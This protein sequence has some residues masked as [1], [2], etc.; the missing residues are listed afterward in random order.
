MPAQ[1]RDLIKGKRFLLLQEMA[2]D[3]GYDDPGLAGLGVGGT[4]LTGTGDDVPAQPAQ[5]S[6]P[7]VDARFVMQASRFTRPM[8]SAYRAAEDVELDKAVYQTTLEEELRDGWTA[9]GPSQKK[10]SENA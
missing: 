5:A 10:N 2:S 7:V 8:N 1:K 9:R 6:N 4:R 3:L